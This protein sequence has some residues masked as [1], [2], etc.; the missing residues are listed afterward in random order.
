[1]FFSL[2]LLTLL[3]IS[4][5]SEIVTPQNK[6]EKIEQVKPT[7]PIT[8]QNETKTATQLQTITIKND[9]EPSMLQYKHWTGTYKPSIFVITINGQT[10][11]QGKEYQVTA[12]DNMLEI[13][14]N[15]SFMNGM[16][17]GAKIVKFQIEKN[18]EPLNLTFSWDNEWRVIIDHATPLEVE[19]TPFTSA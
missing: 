12:T 6:T 13:G 2:Y 7:S 11:E 16:R 9:I 4:A 5:V 19:K 18:T 3:P 17:T 14:Y 10:I 8:K 15:Y 1:M